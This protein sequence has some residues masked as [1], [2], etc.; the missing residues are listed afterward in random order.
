MSRNIYTSSLIID[1]S[2][3]IAVCLCRE[4]SGS[5][6][7]PPINELNAGIKLFYEAIRRNEIASAA[8]YICSAGLDYWQPWLVLMTDVK[9][10][11][12]DPNE[13][14]RAID[15]T[16]DMVHRKNLT[17]FPVSIGSRAYKR[18]I[19]EIFPEK[20]PSEA[21]RVECPEIF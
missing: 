6:S 14:A 11:G 7:G 19:S 15:R 17:I 3:R 10:E 4:T 5:M 20:K 8:A 1:P 16:S 9:P 12:H 18:Y 13:L 2:P 21:K